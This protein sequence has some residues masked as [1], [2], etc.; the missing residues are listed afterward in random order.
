MLDSGVTGN[1]M[2][3][4]V[5]EERGF[6]IQLKNKPYL[7]IVV[8]REPISTNKGMVTHKTVLLEMFM[9]YGHKETIQFDIIHM[10]SHMYILGI[11]WLKKYNP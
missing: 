2:T 9:L 1:F 5:A 8:D 3:K 10:D 7:L 6:K 11:L 4:K